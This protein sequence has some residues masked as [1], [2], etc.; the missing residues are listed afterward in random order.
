MVK[1]EPGNGLEAISPF[2]LAGP[3][4]SGHL[5]VTL[6]LVTLLSGLTTKNSAEASDMKKGRRIRVRALS[7]LKAPA[8]K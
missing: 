8:H 5:L 2:A 3:K 1:I 7:H 6:Q 4:L